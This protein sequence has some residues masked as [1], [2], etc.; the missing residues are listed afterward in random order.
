[1][2]KYLLEYE[3]K[4]NGLT[5][6]EVAQRI[7]ISRSAFSKKINGI[8]EFTQSEIQNIIRLLGISDPT[9]IFFSS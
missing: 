1:M 2:D 4:R 8:S 5:A 6:G 3:I 9:P 7:G